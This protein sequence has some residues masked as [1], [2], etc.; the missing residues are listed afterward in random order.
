MLLRRPAAAG[1]GGAGAAA[2]AEAALLLRLAGEADATGAATAAPLRLEAAPEAA[3]IARF[4]RSLRIAMPQDALWLL[5]V[6]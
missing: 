4:I 3:E 2:A 6:H 1:L 5:P